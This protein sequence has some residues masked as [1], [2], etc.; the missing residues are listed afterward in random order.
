M[1]DRSHYEVLGIAS[2]ASDEEVKKAVKAKLLA[3]HPDKLRRELTEADK[4]EFLLI[5][6]AKNVL[7]DSKKRSKYDETLEQTAGVSP[8]LASLL[9]MNEAE[10]KDYLVGLPR[11]QFSE[12]NK[13]LVV[14]IMND[15]IEDKT[16]KRSAVAA[17]SYVKE[18]YE[19]ADAFVDMKGAD[20]RQLLEDFDDST[21]LKHFEA[22]FEKVVTP[23]REKSLNDIEKMKISDP[24][25]Q[26][27]KAGVEKTETKFRGEIKGKISEFES[28]ENVDS[29]AM[30]RSGP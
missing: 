30:R 15:K 27:L 29:N 20:R 8:Q 2:N 24:E 12:L 11:D 4:K 18:C 21:H 13:K 22:V 17:F 7:C 9:K 6:E 1:Q 5:T 26:E 19:C 28:R 14:A 25:K 3:Y 23:L 16:E 10:K